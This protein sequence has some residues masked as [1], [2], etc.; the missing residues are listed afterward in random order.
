MSN[1][2]YQDANRVQ[3]MVTDASVSFNGTWSS[4]GTY[5]ASDRDVVVYGNGTYIAIIDN[6]GGVPTAAA[7]RNRPAKW[8]PLVRF[9]R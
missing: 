4:S 7:R 2:A 8:S 5:A 9:T 1:Y 6:V 3:H